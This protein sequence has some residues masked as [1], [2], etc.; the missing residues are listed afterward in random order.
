MKTEW[1][2]IKCM[3]YIILALIVGLIVYLWTMYL[4]GVINWQSTT[5]QNEIN[6][7]W[8]KLV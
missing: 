7:L 2:I 3:E 8:D 1:L 6:T 5:I 4:E